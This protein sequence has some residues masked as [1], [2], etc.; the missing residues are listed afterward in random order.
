MAPKFELN[1]KSLILLS[2]VDT[3]AQE[4]A[5]AALLKRRGG[6]S[7]SGTFRAVKL[8]EE[9]GIVYG[10]ALTD[11]T[12]DGAYF[13]LQGDNVKANNDLVKA[14]LQFVRDGAKAD[15]MHDRA[16]KGGWVPFVL[17]VTKD[18]AEWLGIEQTGLI[19]GMQP[20]AEVFAKFKSGELKGFSIDGTGDRKAV[21]TAGKPTAALVKALASLTAAIKAEGDVPC[22]EC[23][24]KGEGCEHCDGSG[25]MPAAEKAEETD[26]DADT[27]EPEEK[28]AEPEKRAT[29][30]KE[31]PVMDEIKKLKDQ[32]TAL[33]SERDVLKGKLEGI[34]KA[35]RD[36][37]VYK[38]TDG[39]EYTAGDDKKLVAMA[40]RAD[41]AESDAVIA[42]RAESVLKHST[43]TLSVKTAVIKAL[44]AIE[45]EATRKAA[46]ELVKAGDGAQSL[47]Q[48]S[49]GHLGGGPSD[50]GEESAIAKWNAAVT[51]TADADGISVAKA[52]A[53]VMKSN[54]D[55][56][57]AVAA[58]RA[59]IARTH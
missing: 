1:I 34:E 40:K 4:T 46:I 35:Q 42:K 43:G 52:S 57:D 48:K 41:R 14:A 58:E 10:W 27:E 26:I 3:P 49:V 32:V 38:A 50:D 33:T 16:A 7:I 37:V 21:K 31:K 11:T 56:Y 8:D 9:L 45:D 22:P 51:K 5:H 25:Y 54:P 18:V 24:G 12:K 59:R 53:K 28:P 23:E 15:E 39:T 36:V 47:L 2:A 6:V 17:P 44:D 13:D 20:T 29:K 55:L 19:A 30:A